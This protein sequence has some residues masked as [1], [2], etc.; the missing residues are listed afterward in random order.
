MIAQPATVASERKFATVF[1]DA[2]PSLA[3][4]DNPTECALAS[5]DIADGGNAIAA[6]ILQP[7]NEDEVG[8]II[9]VARREGCALFPRGGGWSYSG[10]YTPSR[11]PAAIVDTTRLQT[12]AGEDGTSRVTVGAGVTWGRLY[13]A[14]DA[15]GLRVPSF[16]PLSGIGATVGGL[17]AQNGGFFGAASHGPIADGGLISSTLIAGSGEKV[18]LSTADRADGSMAPQPFA[19]DCGAFGIRTAVTLTTMPRPANVLFASF[20]FSNGAETLAVLGSLA[21]LAGLGEAFVFDP[22]T[23]ANLARSGFSLGESASIAGDLLAAGKG[24]LGGIGDVMR[25]ARWSKAE[26]GDIAWSLHVSVEGDAEV[27]RMT[28]ADI[29]ARAIAGGGKPIPDVIPRVTRARP[30]RRIKALLG[31][32][33][34]LWL[35]AHGVFAPDSAQ[36]ALRAVDS[37]FADHAAIMRDHGIRAAVL[38]TLMGDRIVVEP[39]LFWPDCLSP[40]HRHLCQPDQIAAFG[41]RQAKPDT[42]A[43]A[44]ALR[45]AL[46]AALDTAGASHFQI[47]RTY[48]AHP[49]V[50]GTARAAWLSW[51]KLL[52]P[53][54][55]INPG[56]LGL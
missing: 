10:G 5:R 52:D 27:T 42:R 18:E 8:A 54:R 53:D 25:A 39:Q 40:L 24:P 45:Q 6:A 35:P 34:E 50:S 17:V 9:A 55:I 11:S 48:A 14:L 36:A 7:Q 32:D 22:G 13:D 28:L 2:A 46:I 23:H 49:R 16:G 31:P 51:K 4:V 43:A 44:H 26:I 47:G 41:A 15:A 33:G 38:A 56:V 30:F 19:G 21:G 20:A 1:R 12:L 3:V 29:E 37:A